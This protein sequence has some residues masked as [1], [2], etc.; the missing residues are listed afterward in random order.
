[1]SSDSA[2]LHRF[3]PAT[4]PSPLPDPLA[5]GARVTRVEFSAGFV[6]NPYSRFVSQYTFCQQGPHKTWNRGFP[7]RNV[8]RYRMGFDDWWTLLWATITRLGNGTL[9]SIHDPRPHYQDG[10]FDQFGLPTRTRE[11]MTPNFWCSGIWWGRC[12]GPASQWTHINGRSGPLVVDWIGKLEN[13]STDF[14]CLRQLLNDSKRGTP[15]GLD[16]VRNS[17]GNGSRSV[18]RWF[19]NAS[20]ARLV[21]LHYADDFDNFGYSQDVP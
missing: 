4:T 18:R 3:E 9:P 19:R 7:C 6:R 17:R 2:R 10:H 21:R 1:M 5:F 20:V 15:W 12:L 13:I 11:M 16:H 14:L 8:H